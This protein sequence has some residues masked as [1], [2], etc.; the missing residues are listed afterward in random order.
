MLEQFYLPVTN[1]F[2]NIVSAVAIFL[3]AL[4]IGKFAGL[5]VANLL[6]ELKIEKILETI[7]VKF[8]ISKTVGVI[9]SLAIY[10]F[11]FILALNQLGITKV[12]IIVLAVFFAILFF[13]AFLLGITDIIRNFFLG[14][15]LRK[16]YLAKRSISSSIVKGKIIDVG[17]TRIKVI[18][19]EKDILMVPYSALD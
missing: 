7:G 17:Y 8:F 13:I 18:T 11:G 14:I 1:V 16:K 4:I 12:V 10:V 5:I 19:N 9:V 6:Y 3:I 15:T 2:L